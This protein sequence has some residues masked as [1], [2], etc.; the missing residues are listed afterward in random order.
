MIWGE[1]GGLR[2]YQS[3]V[4]L[5]IWY[6]AICG[7]A[8]ISLVSVS[9]VPPVPVSTSAFSLPSL[10]LN[11]FLSLLPL[12]PPPPLSLPLLPSP[13][14]SGR[15]KRRISSWVRWRNYKK[16]NCRPLTW[17]V[18]NDALHHCSKLLIP[19]GTQ[20]GSPATWTHSPLSASSID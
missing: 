8:E 15:D 17:C 10:L 4:K 7:S 19:V 6:T 9:A 11:F 20:I 16:I 5:Q 14:S 2:S 1:M 18:I 12:L 3:G 13:S